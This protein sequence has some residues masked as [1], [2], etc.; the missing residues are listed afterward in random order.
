MISFEVSIFEFLTT[1]IGLIFTIF[2]AGFGIGFAIGKHLCQKEIKTNL[3]EDTCQ[4][5]MLNNF[6][7]TPYPVKRYIVNDKCKTVICDFLR[8]TDQ[9][10]WKQ[11]NKLKKCK[12]DFL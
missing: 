4:L 1:A 7:P 6:K 3:L 9:C 5:P 12:C 11:R 10:S 2:G 8:D